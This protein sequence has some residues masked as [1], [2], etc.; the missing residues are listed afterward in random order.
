[1][2]ILYFS[3]FLFLIILL[4]G[5]V[6]YTKLSRFVEKKNIC[7]AKNANLLEFILGVTLLKKSVATLTLGNFSLP[8]S[9]LSFS[10]LP[11]LISFLC[12]P[13]FKLLLISFAAHFKHT[14]RIIQVPLFDPNQLKRYFSQRIWFYSYEAL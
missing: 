1:M 10:S 4:N 6:E 7:I 5:V 14:R 3:I 9:F 13:T 8:P 12:S 11:P 2:A